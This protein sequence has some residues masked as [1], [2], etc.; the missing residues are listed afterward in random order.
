MMFVVHYSMPLDSSVNQAY[1]LLSIKSQYVITT[2]YT[3]FHCINIIPTDLHWKTKAA[4]IPLSLSSIADWFCGKFSLISISYGLYKLLLCTQ[5][6]Q[7]CIISHCDRTKA[8][9]ERQLLLIT[10]EQEFAAIHNPYHCVFR[11]KSWLMS[12]RT[13]SALKYFKHALEKSEMWACDKSYH[14]RTKLN[15]F[16]HS[17]K[18]NSAYC[19]S[20]HI[21]KQQSDINYYEHAH[22]RCNICTAHGDACSSSATRKYISVPE[23]K[24]HYACSQIKTTVR[25]SWITVVLHLRV[26]RVVIKYRLKNSIFGQRGEQHKKHSSHIPSSTTSSVHKIN[27]KMTLVLIA[28]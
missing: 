10:F 12:Y 18:N 17:I 20:Y 7:Q 1:T 3:L 8:R 26:A 5:I 22:V 13:A 23:N 24:S 15:D 21:N 27:I 25:G 16:C 4:H 19:A 6:G 2:L 28:T 14:Q 9:S 11:R